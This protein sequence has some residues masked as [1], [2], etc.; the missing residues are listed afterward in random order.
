MQGLHLCADLIG[1][2]QGPWLTDGAVLRD[3]CRRCVSEAG[4]QAVAE[5]FHS[6]EPAGSGVTGV[7]LLAESHL[8]VHTWPEQQ[9][10]TVDVYVCNFSADNRAKAHAVLEQLQ[11]V[12]APQVARV[13]AV[14]RGTIA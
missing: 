5:C 1:C 6:F 13:Q 8:A 9:A 4:L 12:F 11:A 10:V 7:V 2:S 14:E 3:L